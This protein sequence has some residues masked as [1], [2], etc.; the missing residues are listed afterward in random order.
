MSATVAATADQV[1]STRVLEAGSG[2][3]VIICLHGA[4]SRADRFRPVLVPLAE[5]G[6]HVYAFD[7]PGHGL[8]TKGD[9]PLSVPYYGEFVAAL[10]EQVPAGRVTVLGTS[11]GGH[12]G[13]QLTKLA[14]ARVDRLAMVGTIG[15]VPMSEEDRVNTSRVFLRNRSFDDCVRK[16]ETLMWNDELVTRDWAEEESLINNSIGAEESFARLGDYFERGI[17]DDL[18]RDA[19]RDR[20]EGLELGLM[21]GDRDVIVTVQVG[22]ECMEALPGTPMVWIR[23]AG[24]APYYERPEDFAIGLELLFSADRPAGLEHSI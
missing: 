20:P 12:I 16:L 3:D 18:V 6:Y 4:G 9:L 7:L 22:R 21:W 23:D 1:I 13:G 14:N 24:H 11:L 15:I 5:R 17:N 2:D 8:A 19:L 10:I